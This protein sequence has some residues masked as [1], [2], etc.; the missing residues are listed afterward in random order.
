MHKDIVKKRKKDYYYRAA[1]T[2]REVYFVE[3]LSQTPFMVLSLKLHKGHTVGYTA[4]AWRDQTSISMCCF[5][6]HLFAAARAE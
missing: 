6:L 3:A 4:C 5:L 2:K 1:R